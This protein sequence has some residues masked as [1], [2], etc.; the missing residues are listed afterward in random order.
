MNESRYK[1]F[2]GRTKNETLEHAIEND[3]DVIAK[4]FEEMETDCDWES[5]RLLDLYL[6]ADEKERAILDA[7]LVY[8]CGWSMETIIREIH[9]EEGEE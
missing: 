9:C 1:F 2:L 6:Q 7:M 3:Y 4:I 5:S 8:L